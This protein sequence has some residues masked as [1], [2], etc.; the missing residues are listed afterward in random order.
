MNNL[1]SLAVTDENNVS[2]GGGN[3]SGSATAGKASYHNTGTMWKISVY[4]AKKDTVT[5]SS[6]YTLTKDY[7]KFGYTFWLCRDGYGVDEMSSDSLNKLYLELGNKE[8]YANQGA[9]FTQAKYTAVKNRVFLGSDYGLVQAPNIVPI[10]NNFGTSSIASTSE[11]FEKN[12]S[13]SDVIVKLAAKAAG[14][15]PEQILKSLT[16]TINGETKSNWDTKMVDVRTTSNVSREHTS[17]VSWVFLYEPVVIINGTNITGYYHG[18][19]ATGIAASMKQGVYNWTSSS[20]DFE[21]RFKTASNRPA[22]TPSASWGLGTNLPMVLMPNSAFLS[23]D[24]LGYKSGTYWQSW[25]AAQTWYVESQLAG[26]GFGMRYQRAELPKVVIQKTVNG[27]Q[28]GTLSG[29]RF[30]VTS[31]STG[32]KWE[33]ITN[34]AG[35][36]ILYLPAGAYTITET[37]K[38][39]YEPKAAQSFVVS[40]TATSATVINVMLNNVT[41]K[42]G[43][44]HISKVAEDRDYS[45]TTFTLSSSEYNS[46][47][48]GMSLSSYSAVLMSKDG[49][50][51]VNVSVTV[52]DAICGDGAECKRINII[53]LPAGSWTLTENRPDRYDRTLVGYNH[54]GQTESISYTAAVTQNTSAFVRYDNFLKEDAPEVGGLTVKKYVSDG[55]FADISFTITGSSGS[56]T[57]GF[58]WTIDAAASSGSVSA[59]SFG[60]YFPT[61]WMHVETDADGKSVSIID[62]YDIPA[63]SYTVQENRPGRYTATYVSVSGGS[64]SPMTGVFVSVA[65]GLGPVITFENISTGTMYI[66]KYAEDEDYSGTVFTV[67]G[68]E[69]NASEGFDYTFYIQNENGGSSYGTYTFGNDYSYTVWMSSSL[70]TDSAGKTYRYIILSGMPAGTYTV[71]ELRPERYG[72]TLVSVSEG[73][74]AKELTCTAV[75]PSAGAAAGFVTVTYENLLPPVCSLKLVKRIKLSNI[76][77]AHG[78]PV[79][80]LTAESVGGMKYTRT[81]VFSKEYVNNYIAEN[82]GAEYVEMSYTLEGIEATDWTVRELTV[83]RYRL[84]ENGVEVRSGKGTVSGESACVLLSRSNKDVTVAF[85]N[86]KYDQSGTTHNHIVVNKFMIAAV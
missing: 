20:T 60:K 57:E 28:S 26:G 6:A 69:G 9:S 55:S 74:K 43:S 36:V 21:R 59:Y 16:F 38:T 63:G 22:V 45:G 81:Y 68:A 86:E 5:N 85:T 66:S 11:F 78:T 64:K 27:S 44:L 42:T 32:E 53:G 83:M 1:S 10:V 39:G 2:G 29:F 25:N 17:C 76:V 24:W 35:Q 33:S 52:T 67:S 40:S 70:K 4:V 31:S 34:S 18:V 49:Q 84:A 48:V 46:L 50:K 41:V 23:E 79:F 3:P 65:A 14:R 30:T 47:K 12:K 8:E 54:A 72:E 75:I 51:S 82:P 37:T 77:Y 61:A 15:T 73:E 71:T 7:H 19:T 58:S 56:E 13:V 62:I 80:F